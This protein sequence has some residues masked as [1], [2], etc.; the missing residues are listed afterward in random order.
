MIDIIAKGV[1]LMPAAMPKEWDQSIALHLD[2][3]P[4]TI[5]FQNGKV[6]LAPGDPP[7]PESVIELTSERLCTIID[8]TIDFMT[9]WRELAEPSPTDR[10][11][12][13]K[14]SGAKFFA[15]LDGLI[16][17]YK[18]NADLKK[19]VDDYKARLKP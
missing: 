2:S 14:G 10:T 9:V 8:G 3:E 6:L 1:E 15:F 5:T 7:E 16:K 4:I 13:K 19:L 18:S 17:C 11:Y 12:I